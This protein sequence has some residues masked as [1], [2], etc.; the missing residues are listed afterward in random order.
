MALKSPEVAAIKPEERELARK[1]L[2][3][4]TLET[5]L[6]ERELRTANL[7]AELGAFER[8]YLHFVGARYA[9]LDELKARIAEQLATRATRQRSS[10][11]SGARRPRTRQ[12]NQIRCRRTRRDSAARFRSFARNEASLS[13][14]RQ[15]HSSRFDVGPRRSRQTTAA[16]EHGQRSIRA[17]RRNAARQDSYGI[18]A[19]P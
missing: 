19:Q 8:R 6:T 14:R 15:T 2:E 11:T 3:Q 18:R 7:R 13:H 10:P 5:E 12:R 4:T 9:E 17:W 1:V 16:D